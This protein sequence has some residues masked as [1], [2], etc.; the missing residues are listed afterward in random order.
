MGEAA[1][2][3]EF[4]ETMA[5]GVVGEVD[6]GSVRCGA[7]NEFVIE[8]VNVGDGGRP[9]W[10]SRDTFSD[11]RWLDFVRCDSITVRLSK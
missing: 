1:L 4:G 2:A 10:D 5:V 7:A 3:N 6:G 9:G 8:T 11:E